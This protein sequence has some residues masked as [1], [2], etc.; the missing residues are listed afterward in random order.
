MCCIKS[1]M[2]VIVKGSINTG[3][4]C[5]YSEVGAKILKSPVV[6]DQAPQYIMAELNST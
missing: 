2:G 5:V 4:I 6:L 1:L 3:R